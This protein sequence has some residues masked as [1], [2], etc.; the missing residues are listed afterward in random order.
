MDPIAQCPRGELRRGYATGAGTPDQARGDSALRED[1]LTKMISPVRSV[2]GSSSNKSL[3]FIVLV[4]VGGVD[5]IRAILFIWLGKI[6]HLNHY[7]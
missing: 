5:F 2:L 7:M 3:T 4:L 1:T 6:S